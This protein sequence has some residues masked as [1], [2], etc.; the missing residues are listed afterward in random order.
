MVRKMSA[1]KQHGQRTVAKVRRQER[2]AR[3]PQ[4]VRR[5]DPNEGTVKSQGSG[6]QNKSQR[7][8]LHLTLPWDM[9]MNKLVHNGYTM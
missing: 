1:G 2:V 6:T 5:T 7:I 9:A 4:C 8:A 3:G